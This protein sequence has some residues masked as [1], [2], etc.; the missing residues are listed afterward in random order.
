MISTKFE[1]APARGTE[2]ECA[3]VE[4]SDAKHRGFRKARDRGGDGAPRNAVKVSDTLRRTGPHTFLPIGKKD[5]NVIACKTLRSIKRRPFPPVKMRD[6][7][8]KGG[9]PERTVKCLHNVANHVVGKTIP[10]MKRP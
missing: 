7:T 4:S 2:P 3:L 5:A 10:G 9:K 8:P 6:S 1:Y